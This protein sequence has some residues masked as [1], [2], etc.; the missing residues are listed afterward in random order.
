[1]GCCGGPSPVNNDGSEKEVKVY[2]FKD[3]LISAIA[4]ITAVLV[5]YFLK[6]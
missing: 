3:Y 5:I 6:K 2:G 4:I 1:M